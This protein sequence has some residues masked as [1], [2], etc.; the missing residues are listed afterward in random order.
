MSAKVFL[1]SDHAGYDLKQ[2]IDRYLREETR[3]NPCDEGPE[4]HDPE[5][6]YPEYILK[7]SEKVAEND[8][9]LGIVLGYSGQGE[10]LAANKVNGIR[11]AVYYGSK[12]EI[13]R[14]SK[15]HNNANVL[16]LGA[17]FL[18]TDTAIE[19][20]RTW[21]KTSFT[22]EE[23]HKRR[24]NE[25]KMYENKKPT[26]ILPS[27]LAS[28]QQQLDLEMQKV[29]EQSQ[30]FHIDIADGRFVDNT[31]MNFEF[32]LPRAQSYEAHLMVKEPLKYVKKH[33]DVF[34]RFNVH[35]ESV[36]E[37]GKLLRYLKTHGKEAG[38]A[39]KPSTDLDAISEIRRFDL[40]QVMTVK[41]GE[42]GSEFHQEMIDRIRELRRRH[43]EASIE[44]DGHVT[45][46]N[47]Q[48]LEEAGAD[49]FVS[50]SYIQESSNPSKAIESL[51]NKV[52]T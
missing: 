20:V 14:L 8:D 33:I 29:V 26:K 7:A 1:A 19:A 18:D 24:L 32:D 3:F 39:I 36:T 9:S 50:G 41:P 28:S 12:P 22:G 13:V 25:I 49:M 47:I 17:G 51:R 40:I 45:P 16:S 15:K 10:A 30:T 2:E 52:N 11:A 48:Q 27:I 23:R 34:D 38:V 4:E 21:L 5:D 31:S 6:D 46:E 43:P 35:T 37:P 44:V 42:Y